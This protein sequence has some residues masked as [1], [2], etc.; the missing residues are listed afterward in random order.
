MK[1]LNS[2]IVKGSRNKRTR[3]V[4]GLKGG[5][6][7][8]ESKQPIFE[9]SIVCIEFDGMSRYYRVAEIS[10]IN[11][12]SV[13]VCA[14]EYGYW[15]GYLSRQKDFDVRSILNLGVN[16]VL[17]KKIIDRLAESNGYC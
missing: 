9:N 3:R 8:F 4:E 14:V 12:E 17:D 2:E 15:G 1:V 13:E 10:T 5:V 16:L 11:T 7:T 6:I